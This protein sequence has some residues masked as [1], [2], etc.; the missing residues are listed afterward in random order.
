MTAAT[1]APTPTPSYIPMP[2][3][4]GYY[5]QG[6]AAGG[7]GMPICGYDGPVFRQ[8]S[9]SWLAHIAASSNR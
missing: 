6:F 9:D 5:D 2:P 1:K 8:F 3:D 4:N 7:V